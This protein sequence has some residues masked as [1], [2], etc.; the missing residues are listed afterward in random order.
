MLDWIVRI[1]LSISGLISSLF[2]TREALNFP[3]VQMM[4]AILVLSVFILIAAFYTD[5]KQFFQR[6]FGRKK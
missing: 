2:V 4:V 6:L 3:I 5:I 1:L